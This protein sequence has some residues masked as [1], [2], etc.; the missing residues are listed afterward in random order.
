M[1][2]SI[3]ND[4]TEGVDKQQ[5]EY[6]LR[7]QLEAIRKELGEGDGD[8]V[9]AM[10]VNDWDAGDVIKAA[11]E[12]G[13]PVRVSLMNPAET[14]CRSPAAPPRSSMSPKRARSSAV[15]P[16]PPELCIVP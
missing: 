14:T 1:A 6:L 8:V 12:S 13:A 5:R 11:V 10:H 7:Q 4:V 16:R 3:R 2:E 15:M 9:A